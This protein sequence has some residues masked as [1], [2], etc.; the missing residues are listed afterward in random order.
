MNSPVSRKNQHNKW[1]KQ[2]PPADTGGAEPLLKKE[3]HSFLL[4]SILTSFCLI[5]MKCCSLTDSRNQRI[6]AQNNTL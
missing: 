2:A 3:R 5:L 4:T 1:T 6:F